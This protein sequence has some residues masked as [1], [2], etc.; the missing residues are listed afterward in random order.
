MENVIK[1]LKNIDKDEKVLICGHVYPDGDCIGSAV[2]LGFALKKLGKKNV[3]VAFTKKE[4]RYDF[5]GSYDFVKYKVDYNPDVFIQVDVAEKERNGFSKRY[6]NANKKIIIDHHEKMNDSGD[7]ISYIEPKKSSCSEII[8][9]IIK[10]MNVKIDKK[11]AKFIYT[12]IISDTG[13][14][15]FSMV[16]PRT[17]EI[18]S[19]LVS[20]GINFQEI[21]QKTYF[22]N[23]LDEMRFLEKSFDTLEVENNIAFVTLKYDEKFSKM[24]TEFV[25]GVLQNIKEAKTLCYLREIEG[26]YVKC[27]LRTKTDINMN[28]I[29]EIFDGGGHN[30]AAGFKIKGDINK[31]KKKLKSELS[32]I[33]IETF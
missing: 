10:K 4:P 25:V 24:D 17:Y 3:E 20:T 22:E 29:A 30:K 5:L 32:R 19:K 21:I 14:L 15:R 12:G 33:K 28:E 31:I 6:E 13:V 7:V 18:V 27:S 2:A 1:A 16:T 9:E 23:T 11:I 26:G 8:Y